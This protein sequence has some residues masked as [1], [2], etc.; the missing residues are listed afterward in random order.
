[1]IGMRAMGHHFYL[2]LICQNCF[3]HSIAILLREFGALI[4]LFSPSASEIHFKKKF[5]EANL[6]FIPP[7]YHN[8]MSTKC[9]H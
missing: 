6:P 5:S 9:K 2:E 8:I 4:S 3:A 7:E 1:M